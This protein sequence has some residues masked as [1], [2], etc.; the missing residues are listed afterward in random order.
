MTTL[1]E[2]LI[3]LLEAHGV[4]TVFGIPGVHTV[5]LYRGLAR[6]KI[7]HITPRHEQGAG[8]MAD[9]Y[10]RASGRPGVAFVITGPGLTNTITAMGQAR[11]DS[12]PMLV[13]SGVN[14]MPTLGKGLGFL[15]ELPDQRGMMEKVALFS[16]RV[17]EAS[18]LPG[19]LAQAFA[20]FSSSR[21]GP[22]HIE[23][24]TDVMVK[25]ADGITALLTNAAP[26]APDGA[27]IAE[28]A[29]LIAAAHRPLILAGGGAKR[30]GEPLQRL[31]ER[32]GA[33]VVQT[34]NAR[35][36][37]HAHPLCVP[38]SPSLKAVRALMAD[39]DLV[40][41][42]GT[43]FGPTD[44]DGY[45][46]GGFVLPANLIRIDIGADQIARRPV[47]VGIQADCAEAIETLLAAIGPDRVAAKD[48]ESRADAARKAAFAELSPAYAAQVHAVETIRDALPGAIIVGDST[49][50]IYAANLYYDHDR[51]GGWFNAATGFGA[52]GYGPPAAI[53]AALAMPGVP[54]VC[55]TGD[56]GFQFTLP[57]LGAALDAPAPVIFV[58]WNNRGYREIETS[59]LDVG[60]EPVGVSPAPPDFC[61]LAEA[62][63]IAAERLA[64]T[65]DLADALK[66]ARATGLP[67]VIEIT[68]D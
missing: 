37:L 29:R 12:V 59:M 42:A 10:A 44:Y 65:A 58:V 46:D 45:S 60:V 55:L 27:A 16:Q 39:A 38:A 6:S 35:G 28:A 53:G 14:A 31:A 23:I 64:G 66:R 9:G 62:Y 33:P 13:I 63:G 21:P 47:S 1:G 54:V 52:L 18:E 19:A 68:I 7:R 2:A 34:A 67:H 61:K 48:G 17:T 41:A 30:A 8:F 26:P 40:I 4:D 3:T 20:L 5:E 57:E 49:Q 15:H 25:P 22:V 51:P 36:L 11:A 50:P 43:E 24:P 32:L 56:G